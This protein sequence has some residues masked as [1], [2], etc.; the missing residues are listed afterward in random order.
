MLVR[1]L[2]LLYSTTSSSSM[3]YSGPPE[4]V[5]VHPAVSK[6]RKYMKIQ[7]INGLWE[8]VFLLSVVLYFSNFLKL[9][10]Y[11]FC[12]QRGKRIPKTLKR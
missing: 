1:H 4:Y 12:N 10:M 7:D 5:R 6:G 3:S 2:T 8:I 9:K 11:S